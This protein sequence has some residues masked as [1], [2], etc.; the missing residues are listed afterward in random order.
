MGDYFESSSF[1]FMNGISY[2]MVLRN[3]SEKVNVSSKG[4][5]SKLLSINS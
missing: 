2:V 1:I 4:K 5:I 3:R